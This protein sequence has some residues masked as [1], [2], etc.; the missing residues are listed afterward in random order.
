M[1]NAFFA[2]ALFSASAFAADQAARPGVAI[3]IV[4][5]T[6]GSMGDPVASSKNA[7]E[8]K[9]KV[10]GEALKAIIEK[11]DTFAKTT[12]VEAT[13]ITFQGPQVRLARWEKA[14][15][16]KWLAAFSDPRA[17]TPLGEAIASAGKALE[18]SSLAKKHIVV[19]TDGESNGELKPELALRKLKGKPG[20]PQVYIIAFDVKSQ[21][22]DAV[23]KEGALVL[24]ATGKTLEAGLTT[25]FSKKILL[26]DEE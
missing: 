19:L 3:A 24:P 17:N 7:Q 2:F 12:P 20:A 4:Y 14:P 6:S 1:R 8:P 13:L 26:E 5:D 10:A 18:G 11:I 9:Y 23:K 16:E 15:F 21:A 25:L 22:F